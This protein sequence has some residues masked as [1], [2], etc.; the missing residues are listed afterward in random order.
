MGL[1]R[2]VEVF[3]KRCVTPNTL[4]VL[5]LLSSIPFILSTLHSLLS[6]QNA[7]RA[8]QLKKREGLV[9]G[10]EVVLF[11]MTGCPHCVRMMPAWDAAAAAGP[12]RGVSMRKVERREDPGLVAQ[13]GIT[14]FPTIAAI[15]GGR[16]GKVVHKGPRTQKGITEFVSY[17]SKGTS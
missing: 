15:G 14:S 1:K 9:S 3:L 2:D 4:L 16:P 17:I 8:H 5:V 11:H 12:R 7:Q 6:A 10:R 13:H